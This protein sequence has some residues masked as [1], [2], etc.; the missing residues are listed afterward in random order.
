MKVDLA[1]EVLTVVKLKKRDVGVLQLFTK[2]RVHLISYYNMV[3]MARN[4][5]AV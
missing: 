3:L 2:F 5:L 4:A 1:L